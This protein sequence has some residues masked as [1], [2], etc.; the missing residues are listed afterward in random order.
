MGSGRPIRGVS[1]RGR[2][3]AFDR[4]GLPLRGV[5]GWGGG[6][7]LE[8]WGCGGCGGP[9]GAAGVGAWGARAGRGARGVRCT[10]GAGGA[11]GGR[12][13]YGC[14][15]AGASTGSVGRIRP[16]PLG[17]VLVPGGF[18]RLG[19]RDR[20]VPVRV[21]GLARVGALRDRD[22]E[23]ERHPVVRGHRVR[24]AVP[25]HP[26]VGAGGGTERPVG[27]AGGRVSGGRV[28]GGRRGGPAAA[29][30]G[31]RRPGLRAA[32]H[33]DGGGAV[34]EVRD[35]SGDVGGGGTGG[36]GTGL[37]VRG[38]RGFG[39]GRSA[40]VRCGGDGGGG[41]TVRGGV[42]GR[43]GKPRQR[44]QRGPGRKRGFGGVGGA[45]VRDR[46][47][48]GGGGGQGQPLDGLRHDV[49]DTRDGAYDLVGHRTDEVRNGVRTLPR[50]R[51]RRGALGREA[52]GRGALRAAVLRRAVLRRAVLRRAVL[53]RAV[54][55]RAVLRRA[56]LCRAVLRSGAV[57]PGALRLTAP[58]RRTHRR[59]VRRLAHR[60][61]WERCP[62]GRLRPLPAEQSEQEQ[63]AHQQRHVQ[64]T[65][66][67]RRARHAQGGTGRGC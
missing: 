25:R 65:P 21:A 36:G 40:V 11:T 32:V 51:G 15:G 53:R 67:G 54:L 13:R 35:G 41:R 63:P 20:D 6:G 18:R 46:A 3:T 37:G 31:E 55:R 39:R 30:P 50:E 45:R 12:R 8:I 17:R 5:W 56:V 64:G 10:W 33:R 43:G 23:P 29:V 19:G 42:A 27:G 52:L 1:A 60:V 59:Q 44:G 14:D 61:P 38:S 22:D 28:L 58:G 24:V 47:A 62:V 16:R 66:P 49:H 2:P 9:G 26:L 48:A 7:G 4:P 34:R 57:R